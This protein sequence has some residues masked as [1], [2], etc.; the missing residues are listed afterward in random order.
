MLQAS[1]RGH[2][3]GFSKAEMPYGSKTPHS[4]C[5]SFFGI[6]TDRQTAVLLFIMWAGFL[7][8]IFDFNLILFWATV[9]L[10]EVIETEKTLYLVMEYA[11]GGKYTSRDILM[12]LMSSNVVEDLIELLLCKFRSNRK[13]LCV[14]YLLVYHRLQ[15][16]Q[17]W[18]LEKLSPR[19]KDTVTLYIFSS[20]SKV[21]FKW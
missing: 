19:I 17:F 7:L 16:Q 10:F 1:Y 11:S 12:S 20:L 15:F 13:L 3:V 2:R 18:Y 4:I 9:Q 14:Y 21:Q 6:K 8:Y 5:S